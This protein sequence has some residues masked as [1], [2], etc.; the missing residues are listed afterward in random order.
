MINFFDIENEDYVQ[1]DDSVS[2]CTVDNW[3]RRVS[4]YNEADGSNTAA[5]VAS[6]QVLA[7]LLLVRVEYSSKSLV[8]VFLLVFQLACMHRG[9][10]SGERSGSDP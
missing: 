6:S 8:P 1:V 2:K 4:I 3:Q 10:P 7:L 5:D 9:D